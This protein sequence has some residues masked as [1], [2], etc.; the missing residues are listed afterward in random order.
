MKHLRIVI[1]DDHEVVRLGLRALLDRALGKARDHREV[2]SLTKALRA[3]GRLG[4][5]VGASKAMQEVMLMVEMAAPTS[6]SVLI[7]G[8]TGSGKSIERSLPS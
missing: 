6:A 8:E 4:E 1:V 2:A 7:T 3:S 5:I